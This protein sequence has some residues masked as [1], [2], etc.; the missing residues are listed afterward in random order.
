MSDHM[1]AAIEAALP[2]WF[3]VVMG[4]SADPAEVRLALLDKESRT[5]YSSALAA[6]LGAMIPHI[7]A[8]IAKEI[9][10]IEDPPLDDRGHHYVD[11]YDHGVTHAAQI[12]EGTNK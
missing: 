11:G 7:R 12:A 4:E 10:A 3:E 9:E 5:E 8:M 1:T 6:A 2:V